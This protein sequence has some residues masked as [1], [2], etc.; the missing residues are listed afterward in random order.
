M[1][2]YPDVNELDWC[3]DAFVHLLET[4]AST[5]VILVCTYEIGAPA[6]EMYESKESSMYSTFPSPQHGKAYRAAASSIR[7]F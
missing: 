4:L 3:F 6:H 7:N 1:E 2:L 5:R